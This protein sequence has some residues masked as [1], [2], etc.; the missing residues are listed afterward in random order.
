M[1]VVA[2]MSREQALLL[3]YAVIFGSC[4]SRIQD[5]SDPWGN[6]YNSYVP[7]GSAACLCICCPASFVSSLSDQFSAKG[8]LVQLIPRPQHLLAI[9]SDRTETEILHVRSDSYLRL[10][11][12]QLECPLRH[13]IV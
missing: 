13:H 1:L 11:E 7:Q 3:L 9:F 5:N 4:T 8:P 6:V 12:G 10:R 2:A